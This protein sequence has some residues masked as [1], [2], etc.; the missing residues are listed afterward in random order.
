MCIG[1]PKC[2]LHHSDPKKNK[3]VREVQANK[4]VKRYRW[5]AFSRII[6]KGDGHCMVQSV[7]TALKNTY[8]EVK[9][10]KAGI[11]KSLMDK[12]LADIGE[13]YITNEKVDP[14]AEMQDYIDRGKYNSKIADLILPMMSRIFSVRIII[15]HNSCLLYTSPSP[16]DS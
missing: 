10:T 9:L 14:V 8:K 2:W 5:D 3:P 15:L 7:L 16:R 6:V 4:I 13:G 11:L 12:L 1:Y